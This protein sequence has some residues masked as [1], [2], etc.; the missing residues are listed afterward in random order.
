MGLLDR[1]ILRLIAPGAALGSGVFLFALLLN[2]LVVQL[3]VL[4][5][6]GAD[7]GSVALALAY[8]VPALLAVAVPSALLFGVLLAF[9]RLSASSELLAMRAGGMSSAR[10]LAPVAVA[11]LLGFAATL[12]LT[13]EVVPRS[14]QRFLELSSELASS[15]LRTEI[16]PRVFHDELLDHKVMLIGAAPPG[17]DWE[18]VFLADTT[19]ERAPTIHAASRARM[20]VVPEDRIAYLELVDVESHDAP[21]QDPG[22][23]RIQRAERIRLPLD[24]EMVFGPETPSPRWDAR[25]MRLPELVAGWE[26]TGAAVYLV[27]IH[28]KFAL[29]FACVAF[30]IIGLALG[31]SPSA[32]GTRAGGF[33]IAAAVVLLYYIPQLVGEELAISGEI[34]P[35]TSMWAT[36]IATV[37]AGILL[38]ALGSWGIDPPGAIRRVIARFAFHRRKGGASGGIGRSRLLRTSLPLIGDRYLLSRF[39]TF[40]GAGLAILVSM[41]LVGL[42]N[43]IISDAF[44]NDIAPGLFFRYLL[45]SLP[46]LTLDMLPLAALAGTLVTFGVLGRNRELTAFRAGG[47]SGARLATPALAG[48]VAV[49]FFSWSLQERAVPAV[50]AEAESLEA[51]IEGQARRA[52]DPRERHWL[53]GPDGAIHHYGAFDSEAGYLEELSIFTT[54]DDGSSLR[55]R[56]YLAS[57]HWSEADGVWTGIG[58]WTRDFGQEAAIHPFAQRPFPGIPPPESFLRPDLVASRLTRTELRERIGVIEAA[59]HTAPELW[60]DFHRRASAPLAS[61]ITVLI[62]LPF[63]FSRSNRGILAGVGFAIAIGILYL[64]TNRLFGFLGDAGV[65]EPPLAAWTP[66]LFFGLAALFLI[67]R[68]SD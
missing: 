66:N 35:W 41:Q 65:L 32:G 58:G 61:L 48:G 30:G 36:S 5:T 54:S 1:Y 4:I 53:M 47:I 55:S 19:D 13:L 29:P 33:V 64:V 31:L 45:F 10:L 27:E 44:E 3:R 63:A 40:F 7:P 46:D 49:A 6:Q 14:N 8:L 18:R 23:Y 37:A 43:G 68:P 28:K 60:V 22:K 59:G 25:A 50:D 56:S 42:I 52:A 57:A 20:V 9:S 39:A 67:L 26:G 16:H 12:A 15:R 17:G 21:D 24:A 62:G 2:E 11:A 38:L 51:R 34:A